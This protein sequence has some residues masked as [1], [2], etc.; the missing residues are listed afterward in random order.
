MPYGRIVPVSAAARTPWI[1]WEER[2]AGAV[3]A[4]AARAAA[5]TTTDARMASPEGVEVDPPEIPPH[6]R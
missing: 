3:A 4:S 2:G 1:S 5:P 6:P